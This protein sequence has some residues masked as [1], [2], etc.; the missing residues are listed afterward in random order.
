MQKTEEGGGYHVWHFEAMGLDHS[1]RCLVWAI[2]LNDDYEG[3]ETEFLEQKRR[4]N[5]P[6]GT[7]VIY[8]LVYTPTQRNTVLKGNKYILTGWYYHNS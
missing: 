7:V 1:S 5:P 8:Q 3:G 4:V 6:A 2:Y